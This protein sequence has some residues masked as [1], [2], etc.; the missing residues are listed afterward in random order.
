VPHVG[1]GWR[2][3]EEEEEGGIRVLP[4]MRSA[5]VYMGFAV[6]GKILVPFLIVIHK[7]IIHHLLIITFAITRS[8]HSF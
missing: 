7:H 2:C 8:R 1:D 4:P 3:G 6:L 5:E